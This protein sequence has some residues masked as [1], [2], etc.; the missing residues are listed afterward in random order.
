M[1]RYRN[2]ASASNTKLTDRLTKWVHNTNTARGTRASVSMAT[3]GDT[4]VTLRDQG[5]GCPEVACTMCKKRPLSR[6]QVIF[7]GMPPRSNI[8]QANNCFKIF[9]TVYVDRTCH[10]ALPL[11]KHS[12]MDFTG[13]QPR[14][15]RSRSS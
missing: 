11:A 15:T 1:P 3:G 14:M 8:F 13:Q 9:T 4:I 5:R 6:H 2:G 12:G 7:L 10:G